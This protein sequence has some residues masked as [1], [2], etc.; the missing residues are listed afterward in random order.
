M[1][2]DWPLMQLSAVAAARKPGIEVTSPDIL[3]E[4]YVVCGKEKLLFMLWKRKYDRKERR[5]W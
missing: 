4:S 1:V 2:S 5:L 3:C